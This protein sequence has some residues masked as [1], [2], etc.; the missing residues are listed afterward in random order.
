MYSL[1]SSSEDRTYQYALLLGELILQGLSIGLVGDLGAGKTKFV[2]G[3]ARGLGIEK[4][5]SSPTFILFV[6]YEGKIP[7]LHGDLYRIEDQDLENID[8]EGMLEEW[9]GVSVIEWADRFPDQ[10]PDEMIWVEFKIESEST[11]QIKV[12]A[13]YEEGEK[14]ISVWMDKCLA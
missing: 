14:V 2:Q 4:L 13:N 5:P 1:K 3:L 6:E 12:W 7:L 9:E 8:I 10:F 11:R